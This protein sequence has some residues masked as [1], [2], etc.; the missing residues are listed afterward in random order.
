MRKERVAVRCIAPLAVAAAT[1]AG[2]MLAPVA[3]AEAAGV[4]TVT[5]GL[6]A[7]DH[8]MVARL[9]KAARLPHDQRVRELRRAAP[10][11]AAHGSITAAAEAN[12]LVV[13]GTN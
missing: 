11:A 1:A 9:A 2:A 6:S 7:A 8:G 10:A 13:T 4:V 5:I 3:P 12:G